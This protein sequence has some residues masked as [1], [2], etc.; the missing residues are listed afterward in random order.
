MNETLKDLNYP[1]ISQEE[2]KIFQQVYEEELII[3]R[4]IQKLLSFLI[5]YKRKKFRW[6]LLQMVQQTIN[7]KS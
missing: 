7:L 2:G 4:C 1:G 5:L 3:L 6:G